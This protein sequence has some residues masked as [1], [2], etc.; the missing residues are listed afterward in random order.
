MGFAHLLLF[1]LPLESPPGAGSVG[2]LLLGLALF[3]VVEP[4]LGLGGLGRLLCLILALVLLFFFFVIRV[5]DLGL[6][7]PVG[8]LVSLVVYCRGRL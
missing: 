3:P 4:L 6:L 7:S 5:I 2:L 8:R 1:L